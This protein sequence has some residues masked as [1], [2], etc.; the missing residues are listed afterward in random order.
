MGVDGLA[1]QFGDMA[2]VVGLHMA[3]ALG[4]AAKCVLAMHIGVVVDLH[5]GLQRHAQAPGIVQYAV[6]VVGNAPGAGVEI[7]AFVKRAVLFEATQLFVVVTPAQGPGA[8][9]CA[10]VVLQNFD[11]VAGAAQL[12]GCHQT[13]HA[14]AQHQHRFA[15]GRTFQ[16][17]GAAV[18]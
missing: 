11:V 7:L 1:Q 15:L 8:A 13:R 16:C 4:L 17:D 10:L 2:L 18:G 3:I 14:G 9:A 5:E 12:K 6:V